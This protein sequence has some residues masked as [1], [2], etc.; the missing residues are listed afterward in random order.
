[1]STQS[2][3]AGA[4]AMN[5]DAQISLNHGPAPATGRKAK[6]KLIRR[7]IVDHSQFVRRSFQAAFLLLNVWLGG[8]FYF[9][10]RSL[11]GGY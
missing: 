1:M 11:K 5:A 4:H 10:V 7:T 6:K 2:S 8:V 3:A 9:W